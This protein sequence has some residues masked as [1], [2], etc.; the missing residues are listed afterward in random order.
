M[1]IMGVS[2]AIIGTAGPYPELKLKL[3]VSAYIGM[4]AVIINLISA[5]ITLLIKL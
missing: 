3:G 1:G 5:V 4:L 2:F